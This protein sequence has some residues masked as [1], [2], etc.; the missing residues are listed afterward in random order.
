[1]TEKHEK[2]REFEKKVAE[3][4]RKQGYK[5]L[6]REKVGGKSGLKHEIDVLV[7]D[8]NSGKI[9]WAVQCKYHETKKIEKNEI[10]AW[11]EICKD[12]D[13]KPAFA[14]SDFTSGAVKYARS[15]GVELIRA[16]ELEIEPEEVDGKDFAA[17]KKEL[18]SI[19]DE[20][21]KFL[22]C[23]KSIYQ[24]GIL[25]EAEK[26]KSQ[27]LIELEEYEPK[28]Y[29]LFIEPGR[30]RK[31]LIK[32]N[33]VEGKYMYDYA[34]GDLE[35]PF[36]I[37]IRVSNTLSEKSKSLPSKID[38]VLGSIKSV[39]ERFNVGT[40]LPFQKMNYGEKC[41]IF[42]ESW[43]TIAESNLNIE[44]A[45][46]EWGKYISLTFSYSLAKDGVNFDST[47]NI[48]IGKLE[49]QEIKA[50]KDFWKFYLERNKN[51]DIE[52]LSSFF[53]TDLR[54]LNEEDKCPIL[55]PNE[56]TNKLK[57]I[58]SI[59]KKSIIIKK[60]YEKNKSEVDTTIFNLKLETINSK[61]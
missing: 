51:T 14:A 41:K 48:L 34:F 21:D 53:D 23:V 24:T 22:F 5:V 13:A 29:E 27:S 31:F 36:G 4:F 18:N 17:W 33:R 19:T 44:K 8:K 60:A 1:M 57:S 52:K 11:I 35:N 61:P 20:V 12:I 56:K 37:Y 58:R 50:I 39:F 42:L 46:E 15:K 47:K 26:V 30:L 16:D 9:I 10:S 6:V 49:N 25:Q 55:N 3:W 59:F 32:L 43:L 45:I 2:G 38:E 7:F 28:L 40:L 54:C